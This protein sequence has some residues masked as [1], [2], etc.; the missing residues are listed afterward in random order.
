MSRFSTAN[1][2]AGLFR[3]FCRSEVGAK[4]FSV[5]M[6]DPE[7][8]FER[9]SDEYRHLSLTLIKRKLSVSYWSTWEPG[10]LL[11]VDFGICLSICRRFL[12]AKSD[13]QLQHVCLSVCP[14][15][16]SHETTRLHWADFHEIWYLSIFR[17]SVGKF[18]NFIQIWQEWQVIY[19]KI[20]THF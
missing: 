14:F 9:L 12:I 7:F 19:I 18:S 5:I 10:S 6:N 11:S 1:M 16:R 4:S 15:V 13:Y 2:P 20:N 8:I 17:N 3:V